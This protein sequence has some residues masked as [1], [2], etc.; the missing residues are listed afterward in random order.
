MVVTTGPAAHLVL[1]VGRT[2]EDGEWHVTAIFMTLMAIE[3]AGVHVY[4]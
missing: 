3:D 2:S 4:I 1:Y